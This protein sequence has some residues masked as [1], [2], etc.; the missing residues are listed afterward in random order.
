MYQS[1]FGL[2]ERP[3]DLTP[4]PRFLVLT[5]GHREALSNLEYGIASRRGITVLVGEAGTGKTTLIQTALQRQPDQVHA[6]YLHNPALTRDE[7]VQMLAA[8][9]QLSAEA[10]QSKSTLLLEMETLM[11]ERQ[12]RGESTVLIIDEAQCLPL[13]LLEEV[14]LLAN[15]ETHDTK[16][17]SVILAGQPELASR[18]NDS[19]LRQLKQRVALRCELRP[20]SLPETLGYVAGRLAAAR[21]VGAQIFSREAVML[22]HERA[23]GIPRTISVIADNALVASFALGQRPV[24]RAIVEEVCRDLDLSEPRRGSPITASSGE[25]SGAGGTPAPTRVLGFDVQKSEQPGP[26]FH[27]THGEDREPSAGPFTA[28]FSKRLLHILKQ[29]A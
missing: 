23:A 3:F 8:R 25:G 1:F 27:T 12:Q 15:I 6:V 7:F 5:P 21:G 19:S 24:K 26:V 14:R 2:Q 11:H 4:N 9:F 18:L 20:L 22:I 10:S 28:R 17:L 13:D 29:R 16:L